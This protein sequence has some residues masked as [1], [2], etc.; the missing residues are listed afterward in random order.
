MDAQPLLATLRSVW[1]D[2]TVCIGMIRDILMYLVRNY[3][4]SQFVFRL[5]LI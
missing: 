5:I 2:H 3:T 1:D 4:V